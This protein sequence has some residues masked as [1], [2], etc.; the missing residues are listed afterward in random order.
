[1]NRPAPAPEPAHKAAV[2]IG[3]FQPFHR[4][5]GQLLE[6][7][8]ALADRVVVVI[9]SAHQARTAKNPWS[10]SERAELIRLALPEAQRER[11]LFLPVRDYYN[12]AR[13]TQAVRSGVAACLADAGVAVDEAQ[14]GIALVGHFKDASSQYLAQFPG[15]VLHP[16][17][18][19]IDIDATAIRASYFDAAQ[20]APGV[21]RTD[22]PAF[23]ARL[24]AALAACADTLH[25]ST[26]EFLRAWTHRPDYTRLAAEWE[27]L[28]EYQL[29]WSGAPWP[30]V[31]VTVDVLVRCDDAV[32]L[33][34]RGQAPGQGLW[35][36]PGGFIDP[37]ETTW[38]SAL[39]ELREETGLERSIDDWRAAH[40]GQAVFDHPDRSLRGRTITHA[41][42]FDLGAGPRPLVEGADDAALARW[43]PVASLPAL[44]AHFLDDHF[45][46]LDHFLGLTPPDDA[47]ILTAVGG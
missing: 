38:Q 42:Y 14:G 13:W 20:V 18:R 17:A 41:F 26:R 2:L 12:N 1:M 27:M 46:M 7:A 45:H 11:V 24:Q 43:M 25:D 31:F 28:R 39:R 40:R 44:E 23:A 21:C 16:V 35:A 3:R 22:H 29:S 32:L 10:W 6:H 33:V 19:S 8:L 15:W 34:Q 37:R 36:L 5:H 30:P 9:G 47:R 4:G